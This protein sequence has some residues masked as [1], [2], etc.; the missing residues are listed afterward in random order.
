MSDASTRAE[1]LFLAARELSSPASVAAYL[2][3]AC[4]DEPALRQRVEQLLRAAAEV[5]GF[6][7][8]N[9]TEAGTVELHP[10][11]ESAGDAI[12]PYKLLQQIGEGGMGTVYMA[13]QTAPIERRVAL[14]IVKPGMDTRKVIA[15][16]EAERQALAMM[17]HPNIARALEAGMTDSGR[18]YFVMELV[19]GIPITEYCDEHYLTTRKRLELFMPVCNAI[20]HAHQKGIIHRDVKPS[21]VLVAH[22]DDQPIPKVIDFGVA[23]AID[24][25]LTEKTMFT[26]FGQVLG[27]FEYMSPEQARFN[28]W[29]V[30]TRT[31][32]YSLGVLLYELLSGETPFD[33]KRLRS[34]AIDEI[35]R[36]IRDEEPPLPSTRFSKSLA[37]RQI[38]KRRQTEAKELGSVIRG[39]LDWIVMKALDKDRTQRYE[40]ANGLKM[41][42]QRFLD[43]DPITAAPLSAMYRIRKLAKRH[44]V[45]VGVSALIASSLLV[46]IL[47]ST[48]GMFSAIESSKRA[49]QQALLARGA[50][51]RAERARAAADYARYTSNI[52]VAWQL[53]LE[54]KPS[55]AR[56]ILRTTPAE[57]RNFEWAKLANLAWRRY[58]IRPPETTANE[59]TAQ[60]WASQPAI[61]IG[62]F[63]PWDLPG[64]LHGGFFGPASSSVYFFHARGEIKKFSVTY[65][66][67]QALYSGGGETSITV[68]TSPSGSKLASFPFSNA[69]II[70][71]VET[72]GV[73][74]RGRGD[75]EKSPPWTCCW[76]PDEAY[77]ATGHMDGSVIVWDANSPSVKLLF[78]WPG[79]EKNTLDL[80]IPPASDSIWSASN[81]GTIRQWALPDGKPLK[82]FTAPADMEV[83]YQKISPSGQ[84]AATLLADGSH[85]VWEIASEKVACH[86]VGGLVEPY[87]GPQFPRCAFSKE[88]S[89]V[90]VTTGQTSV[91]IYDLARGNVIN[92][93]GGQDAWL[94]GLEF[95][96]DGRL[97]LTTSE[98]GRA[99]IWSCLPE[100]K[101]DEIEAHD[102]AVYQIDIDASSTKLLTGS[103]DGSAAVWNLD[104]HQRI[105][106]FDKHDAEIVAV[107]LHPD[108]RRAATLDANG[109]LYVWDI[110]TGKP[111]FPIDPR[112]DEFA[113]HITGAGGGLR[114]NVLNFS[115][116]LSTGIFTPRG[117]RIVAY[118]D[119]SMKAFDVAT[120]QAVKTLREASS[121]GWPVY[122]Y[123]SKLVAIL[124]MNAKSIGVWDIESGELLHRLNHGKPLVMLDFSPVANSLV[125]SSMGSEIIVWDADTGRQLHKLVDPAGNSTSCQFSQDGRFI[126][127]GY[128]DSKVRVW[129]AEKGDLLTTLAGHSQRIRGT[130][131][132]PDGTRILT[133][134]MDDHAILWDFA[135]P[136]ASQLM[137]LGDRDAKLVQAHWTTDGRDIVAAW[138]DG[139]IEVWH[140]ATQTDIAQLRVEAG[141]D[142]DHAFD[143]W[144]NT[145]MTIQTN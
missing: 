115:S 140:G 41:D 59:M 71:D 43:G 9:S 130:S 74:G 136:Q 61:A 8:G 135:R 120:G 72:G 124:E 11:T 86:L 27:T 33:G 37:Q 105:T 112:S 52:P 60:F 45:A 68:A 6:L 2:D 80:Y 4:R 5:G 24:Q 32:I 125:T 85:F 87:D 100:D 12:G 36:I 126:L 92:H 20:Q 34:A 113:S 117:T 132:N 35:M 82:K 142:F 53:L 122:S 101:T 15:R 95:S 108:G 13:E 64:G 121:S 128:A 7:E 70:Y 141:V 39:E 99:K 54:D 62:D 26:E 84:F 143:Q 90:A 107:D 1:D 17:D 138:S 48:I 94:N 123:D 10:V 106:E 134:A 49:D 46:G 89:C 118:Q 98:D 73:V 119:D 75:L 110:A 55:Q 29:D 22:Y 25:R 79:H 104:N 31:D 96:A 91:T 88:E 139:V 66:E 56:S 76:S 19:K 57:H 103:Y 129:D 38:A 63:L 83:N 42:V 78:E 102:D 30:D 133:W 65:G 28:Q 144:R 21:N 97:L 81:D 111:S 145:Y 127:A 51:D 93:I 114:S 58:G 18:P 50:E 47:G 109:M 16:F 40:T 67:E 23:K 77:L 131:F 137:E 116:V 3:E 69:A 14:K 44:R